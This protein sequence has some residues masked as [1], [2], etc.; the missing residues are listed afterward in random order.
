E[1]VGG[2]EDWLRQGG[3]WPQNEAGKNEENTLPEVNQSP[4]KASKSTQAP[5][6]TNKKLSYKDQRELD[7]LPQKIEIKEQEIAVLQENISA[8]GFYQKTNDETTAV[9]AKFENSEKELQA[10]YAR[11]EELD[12]ISQS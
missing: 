1:Y 12:A 10:L 3:V 9:L 4:V 2:Y 11:W 6:K 5:G 7:A 8:P